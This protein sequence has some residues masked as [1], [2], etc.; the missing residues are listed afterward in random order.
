MTTSRIATSRLVVLADNADRRADAERLAADLGVPFCFDSMVSPDVGALVWTRSRLEYRPAS[1]VKWNPLF[2]DF[3]DGPTGFR[4]LSGQSRKQPL[5][6]AV[7]VKG[8]S[9]SVVDATAGLGRDAFLLACLGCRVTLV[10]RSP[11]L[12]ALLNDGLRRAVGVSRSLDEVVARLTLIFADSRE[13]LSNRS[14]EDRP[15]VVYLDPMY[16][17]SDRSAA[18]KKEVRI[19]RELVGDDTDA[20]ELFGVARNA[21]KTRVVVKRHPT[22][23]PLAPNPT[24]QYEGRTVRY[25]AYLRAPASSGSGI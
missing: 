22:A 2:V 18:S 7:G 9:P 10:E 25:D 17:S 12:H 15:D 24:I 5:A 4:R 20:S 3:V 1:D 23:A 19:C 6:R 16:E 14:D 8:A 11:I 13:Y 21:A